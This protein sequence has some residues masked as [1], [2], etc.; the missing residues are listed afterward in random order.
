M[1]VFFPQSKQI[2]VRLN[3]TSNSPLEMDRK[4]YGHLPLCITVIYRCISHKGLWSLLKE[5]GSE[6]LT[7]DRMKLV[8]KMTA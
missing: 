6:L 8:K 4:M 7:V 3:G 5:K 2:H 1:L